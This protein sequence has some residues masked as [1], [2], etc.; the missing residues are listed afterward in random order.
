[1]VLETMDCNIPEVIYDDPY[2]SMSQI[3]MEGVKTRTVGT[4][5]NLQ[6]EYDTRKFKLDVRSMDTIYNT[7]P[8]YVYNI[9]K[10]FTLSK[11]KLNIIMVAYDG[12]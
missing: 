10:K 11:E 9:I 1:M 7:I 6:I 5:T 2:I 8:Y 3:T 12:T 4:P